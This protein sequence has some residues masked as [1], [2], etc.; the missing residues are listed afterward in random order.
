LASNGVLYGTTQTGGAYNDGTIF[1]ITTNGAFQT[2]VPFDLTNG[3]NPQ[4]ALT[5]G[6]DGNFYGTTEDGGI[7]NGGTVFEMTPASALTTLAYLSN[8]NNLNP[9]TA[10]VQGSNGNFY[11]STENASKPGDGTIFEMASNGVPDVIYSFMGGPDGNAAVG[12]LAQGMDGNFYG[13]TTGGGANGYGGVFRMTPAGA[14]TNLYSFT[15][16]T[17]GYNPIGAL[18]LGT[19]GNFSGVTR[20]NVIDNVGFVGTIFKVSTNGTLTTLYALNPLYNGDGEYPFAGL[21]EGADGNFYGTTL[22][23]DST[24]N[25]T[26]FRVTSAG[27]FTTLTVFNGSDDG[28]QPKAALVQDAEGNFYGTTAVGGL[29]G[30]GS[31]FRL[32]ITS[33]PQ[34]TVQPSDQVAVLGGG[35]Q[36]SVAVFGASPLNFRWQKNGLNLTNAGNISGAASRILTVN[37]ITTNDFATYSVTVSN[38]LGSVASSGATLTLLGPPVLQSAA[39]AGGMITFTW[40]AATGQSYQV[41]TTTN[42]SSAI[43]ADAGGAVTATSSSSSASYAIGTNA[44]QFYRILLLP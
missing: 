12:A 36:F 8:Q 29:Y 38:A 16:G 43:W 13:L 1:S 11:G 35:A 28:E 3:S 39:Q 42:L 23:S 19:D 34:I 4:A 25:G 2:L 32:T 41:Q 14:L 10:L 15:G 26:L 6:A 5:L 22:Y 20:R 24:V 21:L 30:K 7:N 33:A 18:A 37:N 27:A 9:Y 44:Q 40:S 17:D 31:I